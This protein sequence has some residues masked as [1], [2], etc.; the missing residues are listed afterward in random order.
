MNSNMTPIDWAKRP[1]QNYAQFSGRASRPEFW[2]FFLATIVA[3]I[4]ARIVDSI[5]GIHLVGPIGPLYILLCLAIIVPSIAVSI[6][7]LHDTG[8]PGWWI[9]LPLVPYILAIILG[10]AAMM[11]GAAS[12]SAMGVGAGVGL[13]MIFMLL[14]LVC[15]ILLIVFYCQAGT[16]GDNQYGPNPYG[17]AGG[18]TA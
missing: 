2:W 5:L 15:G 1:I 18:T 6:R 4:V 11:G 14:A 10:G 9:L 7:R 17:D 13:A 12:G 8:R 3:G 16:P